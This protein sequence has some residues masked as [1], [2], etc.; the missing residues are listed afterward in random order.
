[1]K[2]IVLT[3]IFL[4]SSFL[5]NSQN[6]AG[7]W[8][9]NEKSLSDGYL[10]AYQFFNDRSFVYHTS[11]YDALSR[12]TSI[13]GT[14]HINEDSIIF[15]VEYAMEIKGGQVIRSV[16]YTGNDSW[17]I[18]GGVL[19]K[20]YYNTLNVQNAI[21]KSCVENNDSIIYIDDRKYFKVD[22]DPFNY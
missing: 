14:Y 9:L 7:I 12:I 2:K 21:F 15:Y 5:I 18:E 10:E 8:Q 17:S 3:L 16:I 4:A 6:I 20:V 1:M 22:D 19:T 13:G 11:Q